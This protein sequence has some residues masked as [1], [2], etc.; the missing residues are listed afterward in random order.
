MSETRPDVYLFTDIIDIGYQAARDLALLPKPR[1][2][3]VSQVRI[4]Y[5]RMLH[6]NQTGEHRVLVFFIMLS[7][8][9]NQC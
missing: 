5:A 8:A 2:L 3:Q 6:A 4:N 9:A 1:K 7:T